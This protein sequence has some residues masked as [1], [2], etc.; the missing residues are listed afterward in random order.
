LSV[1]FIERVFMRNATA[2]KAVLYRDTSFT[3]GFWTGKAVDKQINLGSDAIS[4]Y[5]IRHFLASD[6]RTTSAAG[7]RRLADALRN[8]TAGAGDLEQKTELIATARLVRGLAGKTISVSDV[9][10]RFNVSAES[11][12]LVDE[13]VH[14]HLRNE[15][16]RLDVGELDRHLPNQSVELDNGGILT[17]PTS[18]F[19]EVFERT[20]LNEKGRVRFA[21]EGRVVNEKLRKSK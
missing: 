15:K 5:W 18:K 12:A 16:F 6:F 20:E 4:N 9:L 10:D 1:E 13:H 8:A 17:A 3:H 19:E 21:T 11:R 7:S 2:Y 14:E